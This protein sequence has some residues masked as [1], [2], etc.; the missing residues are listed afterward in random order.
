M[1][2]GARFRRGLGWLAVVGWSVSALAGAATGAGGDARVTVDDISHNAFGRALPTM[3]PHRWHEMR[4]GKGFFVHRWQPAGLGP[5][6]LDGLGPLYNA[7]ACTSCH[8]KDGRGGPPS[9]PEQPG[10]PH[11]PLL[12]RLGDDPPHPF[13]GQLQEFATEGSPEGKVTVTYREVPFTYPDGTEISLREPRYT[14]ETSHTAED[15]AP[16]SLSPRVPPTL[17]GMGLLEAVAREDILSAA[18]PDDLDG[19]GISGRPRWLPGEGEEGE[20]ERRLGRFGWKAGQPTLRAQT[21][22]AL[23]EDMGILTAAEGDGTADGELGAEDLRK[24]VLYLQLLAPPARRGADHPE[25]A[26]GEALFGVTG[27]DACH[28]PQ[29]TT[30]AGAF[31]ELEQQ[32]IFPYTDL[33]LHDLGPELADPHGEAGAEGAEWR[34]APLWGLGLLAR[35]NG[36]AYFLHDGRAR[37]FEEA[38]LWHGGEARESRDRFI[39]LSS[40]ERQQ[41]LRFLESL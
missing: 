12:F 13:G 2:R 27:C 31:P 24:L 19:D 23:R 17:V 39:R 20:A 16:L 40:A 25:V 37:S 30:G 9:F 10:P 18:D 21:I 34:T 4:V 1:Y 32:V 26:A 11:P 8:F 28:R 7:E 3:E 22:A 5:A 36:T 6:G 14:V 33:L 35:V 15:A 29:L 41:L 38:I